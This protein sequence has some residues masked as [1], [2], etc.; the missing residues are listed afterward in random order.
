MRE[1]ALPDDQTAGRGRASYFGVLPPGGNVKVGRG[2][3]PRRF[4]GEG[5]PIIKVDL[6][7]KR[8]AP[9]VVSNSIQVSAIQFHV[10]EE[11]AMADCG[12]RPVA[13]VVE[14]LRRIAGFKKAETL[15]RKIQ[16]N[17][18]ANQKI[19]PNSTLHFGIWLHIGP[20]IGA[21]R[22][23]FGPPKRN[24][25]NA[26]GFAIRNPAGKIDSPIG[27]GALGTGVQANPPTCSVPASISPLSPNQTANLTYT[28][29]AQATTPIGQYTITITATSTAGGVPP[30]ST[31][32]TVLV[33]AQN[34]QLSNTGATI[35]SP[36]ASGSSTI[37]IS[38][39]DGYTG[40]VTMSCAVITLRTVRLPARFPRQS[41]SL[42]P[43]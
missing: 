24:F 26:H 3:L 7:N 25:R 2:L 17:S 16:N 43:Q 15:V 36:G 6:K 37:T 42:V 11:P 32:T 34:Y 31:S 39:T 41:R 9:C 4:T 21:N 13:R 29:T 20:R 23:E 22:T 33:G 19:E 8:T 14:S 1:G 5:L 27:N 38:P 28:V 35:A 10:H 12:V 18:M 30:A 40:Q